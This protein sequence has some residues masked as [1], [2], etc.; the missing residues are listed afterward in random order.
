MSPRKDLEVEKVRP[1][2]QL[3]TTYDSILK[4]IEVL[5]EDEK[6]ISVRAEEVDSKAIN[7]II[8]E[9]YFPKNSL[10]RIRLPQ[11]KKYIPL[12]N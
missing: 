7:L 1:G 5:A 3:V 12:P 4:I 8:K 11:F 10:G 6:G 2:G 9:Y